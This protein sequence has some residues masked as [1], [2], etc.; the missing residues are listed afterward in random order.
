MSISVEIK[1]TLY[2]CIHAA[3]IRCMDSHSILTKTEVK[4]KT[5][6]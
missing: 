1:Y 5:I 4:I 3:N 6:T 2:I